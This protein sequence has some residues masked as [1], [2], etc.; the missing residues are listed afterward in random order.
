MNL[1]AVGSKLIK[2]SKI[3][4][5]YEITFNVADQKCPEDGSD[6]TFDNT[7]LETLCFGFT[8]VGTYGYP[9]L[10]FI[11]FIFFPNQLKYKDFSV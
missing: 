7:E 9:V 8:A 3:F 6:I 4:K 1:L 10:D 2:Q 5:K 11:F